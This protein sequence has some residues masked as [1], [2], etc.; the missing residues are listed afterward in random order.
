MTKKITL[1]DFLLYISLLICTITLG[2]FYWYNC[3]IPL[4]LFFVCLIKERQNFPQNIY[5]YA[6]V[7]LLVTGFIPII[8]TQGDKQNA[9]YEYEQIL[10]FIL[11]FYIGMTLKNDDKI[12]KGITLCAAI[13][14]AVGLLSYCNIINIE[15]FVFYD[16]HLLRLQSLLKYANTTAVLLG[17]GYFATLKLYNTYQNRCLIYLSS[18]ILLAFY[19]TISKAAIPIFLLIGTFLVFIKKKYT[20]FFVLQNIVC[21]VFTL[22]IVLPQLALHQTVKLLLIITCALFSDGFL[23]NSKIKK[24]HEKYLLIAWVIGFIILAIC[25]YLL[26]ISMNIN[27]FETFFKRFEYMKDALNLLRGN[28]FTGIGPGA[29]RYYQYSIQTTQYDV[30]NIHNGWLQIWLEYGILFFL[31]I[32]IISI[33]SILSLIKR[34]SYLCS[35]ILLFI[36]IHTLIDINLSFG[37]IL[38]IL[39]LISGFALNDTKKV[40]LWK[41]TSHVVLILCSVLILYM[42]CECTIRS[43][44]ENAYL[45]NKTEDAIKYSAILEKICPYDSNLQISIAALTKEDATKRIEYA[46]QLSPIDPKLVETDIEYSIFQKRRNV[47]EKIKKYTTMSKR[48][49]STYIKAKEY[50]T[51]ALNQG[52][53]SE[54]EYDNCLKIIEEQR[55]YYEVIDRNELLKDIIKNKEES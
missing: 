53:C 28:W 51:R 34:K 40:L 20:R 13:T 46:T 52:L 17:C 49:E 2:G 9:L 16:R 39:G 6:P 48:Q 43:R 10:C 31:T 5:V 14:A 36:I 47:I 25:G 11:P 32:A 4:F 42:A 7:I 38:M 37:I 24:I 19:L 45:E 54:N 23:K 8:L 26:F 35:A 3:I 22:L 50:L 18:F 30:T 29:W 1:T 55:K 33:K 27:V 44:F 12:L 21:M 41:T 15:D